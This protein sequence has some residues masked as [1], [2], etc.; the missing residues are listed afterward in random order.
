[1]LLGSVAVSFSGAERIAERC[2]CFGDAGD[3]FG[4]SG[5]SPKGVGGEVVALGEVAVAALDVEDLALQGVDGVVERVDGV[6]ECP[7]GVVH[8][9]PHGVRDVLWRCGL[10]AV[11]VGSVVDLDDD[12]GV[13]GIVD[14]QQDA[15]V[16][17]ACAVKAF[18]VVA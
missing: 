4:G 11:G 1:M 9:A 13:V 5:G 7:A 12:D 8:D 2:Q 14:A 16:A 3:G 17:A 15:V 10:G 18:E 6:V